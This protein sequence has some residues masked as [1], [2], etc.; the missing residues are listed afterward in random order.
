[1]LE[2]YSELDKEFDENGKLHSYVKDENAIYRH[3]GLIEAFSIQVP[4][5]KGYEFYSLIPDLKDK[6]PIVESFVESLLWRKVE[7]INEESKSYVNEYV[8]SY[9]GTHDYFWEII[10]SVTGIPN[11]FFNAHFL[12]NHLTQFSLAERDANWTQLLKYKYDDESS[13]KRLI[14]WAWSETDKSH[15]SN[16]SVLLSSITLAWFHTSTNR[17]LRDCSTKALIC[18]LQNRLD[19]LISL[20][21]MFKEV[22]DPYVYERLFAVAYGCVLRSGQRE[23]IKELL[24]RN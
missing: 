13:V 12:H 16:E 11:H 19:I 9:Q 14:D 8:F 17:K 3:K 10:L 20:L 23:K 6:Y 4:E 21:K 7:T 1:M 2:Q 24:I 15:I 22:N 18:L 5:K